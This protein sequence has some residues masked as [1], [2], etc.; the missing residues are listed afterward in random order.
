DEAAAESPRCAR[1]RKIA[2]GDSQVAPDDHGEVLEVGVQIRDHGR[3]GPLLGAVD[4]GR[5]S[6]TAK[7]IVHVAGDGDFNPSETGIAPAR[8]DPL[9]TSEGA[10]SWPEIQTV[11]V[12]QSITECLPE[13]CSAV[14][15][16]AAANPDDQALRTM[17]DRR[18]NELAGSAR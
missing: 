5:P 17:G 9:E 12:E 1:A 18:L 3:C 15:G 14:I 4:C 11:G 2:D 16:G 13:P 8:V 7:R 10:P 6:W